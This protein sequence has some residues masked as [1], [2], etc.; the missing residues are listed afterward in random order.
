MVSTNT[1]AALPKS[2]PMVDVLALTVREIN[3]HYI[4]VQREMRCIE[5]EFF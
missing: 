1:A 4:S 2:V 3:E 5:G